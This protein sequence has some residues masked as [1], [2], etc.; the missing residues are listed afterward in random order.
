[1]PES[2]ERPNPD[3]LNRVPADTAGPYETESRQRH[4][5]PRRTRFNNHRTLI[6]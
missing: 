1:M 6:A 5:M 2:P 3:H 4:R